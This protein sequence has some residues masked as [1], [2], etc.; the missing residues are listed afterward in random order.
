MPEITLHR[1]RNP[2]AQAA[3]LRKG[4]VHEKSRK[5]KRQKQKSVLRKEVSKA[6][7][8]YSGH[9]FVWCFVSKIELSKQ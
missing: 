9:S 4:G 3:I 5:S 1:R 2:V 8:T 6:M 7:A